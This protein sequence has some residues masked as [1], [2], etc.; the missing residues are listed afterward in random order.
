MVI[1]QDDDPDKLK[2][3]RESLGSRI[4]RYFTFWEERGIPLDN[5]Q[6]ERGLR[7]LVLKRK[8][9]FGSKTQK[10]A[11]VLSI[12]YSVIFTLYSSGG[13]QDFFENYEKAL[14]IH[15]KI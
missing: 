11:N 7:K 12:L 2:K 14:N 8:K 4:N 15:D 1:V 6:A 13:S 3:I 5:N 9:S 10:G